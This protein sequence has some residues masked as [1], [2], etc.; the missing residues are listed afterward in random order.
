MF[1]LLFIFQSGGEV[2]P[3]PVPRNI[4]DLG[5]PHWSPTQLHVTAKDLTKL[6]VEGVSVR[7]CH[8]SIFIICQFLV[9]SFFL[10][11]ELML[12]TEKLTEIRIFEPDQK[13]A[14]FINTETL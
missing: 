7:L 8:L 2:N 14:Y 4:G 13:S 12:K 11:F 5:R 10:C 9:N 3:A 6:Q 1:F